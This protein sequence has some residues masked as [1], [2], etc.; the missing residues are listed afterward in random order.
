MRNI[1][2]LF[3]DFSHIYAENYNITYLSKCSSEINVIYTNYYDEPYFLNHDV[4]MIYIGSM[5]DSKIEKCI[6]KLSKYKNKIKEMIENDVI[7]LITGN[8]L[9]IFS[10]YIEENNK[11]IDG[12]GIFDY[13]I[14]KDMRNKHASWFIGNFEDIKIVGH[15]NQFSKCHNIKDPFIKV[16]GGFGSDLKSDYE[17]IHYHNFYATYILGPILIM[18]PYF[19]R[20]ILEKLKLSGDLACKEELVLAYED[21]K[22][23]LSA[24][25]AIYAMGDHF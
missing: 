14:E 12:L 16:D 24:P 13:Y 4:D 17:G 5:P 15:R 9:E 2:V 23:K 22:E 6:E 19:A 3:P 20:Y 7:F 1:E 25:D 18:N 10:A 11:K 8:A 21:R